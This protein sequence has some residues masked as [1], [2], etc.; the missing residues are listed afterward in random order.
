M[1]GLPVSRE[2]AATSRAPPDTRGEAEIDECCLKNKIRE[3][4]LVSHA[5][6]T[7]HL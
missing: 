5:R 7:I 3:N 6:A 1:R 2:G 4:A